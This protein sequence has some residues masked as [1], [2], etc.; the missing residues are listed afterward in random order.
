MSLNHLL[1]AD[2]LLLKSVM[3]VPRSVSAEEM[4]FLGLIFTHGLVQCF[5]STEVKSKQI[6]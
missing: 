4:L 1:K 2:P 3:S 6:L 5:T